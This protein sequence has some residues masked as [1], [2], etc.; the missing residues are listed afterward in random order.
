MTEVQNAGRG[1]PSTDGTDDL[2]EVPPRR[3]RFRRRPPSSSD[4]LAGNGSESSV[5][6]VNGGALRTDEKGAGAM[7]GNGNGNGNGKGNGTA[8]GNGPPAEPAHDPVAADTRV[9]GLAALL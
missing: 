2:G 7:N 9:S 6:G 3:R 8:N 5:V 1:L 4:P